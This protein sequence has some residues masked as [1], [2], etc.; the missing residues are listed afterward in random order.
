L[1]RGGVV[2]QIVSLG[3]RD[4]FYRMKQHQE[5]FDR[6][7]FWTMDFHSSIDAMN[8]LSDLLKYDGDVI[9]HSLLK[10]G[11]SLPALEK[12]AAVQDN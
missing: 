4:L 12:L 3:D 5:I 9:R 6:G 10:T 7:T 8:A 11:T 2:R 1:D